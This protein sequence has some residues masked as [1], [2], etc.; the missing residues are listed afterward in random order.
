MCLAYI[1][2]TGLYSLERVNKVIEKYKHIYREISMELSGDISV[3][4]GRYKVGYPYFSIACK[5][6]D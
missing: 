4:I 2:V 1:A 5:N 3:I 6:I